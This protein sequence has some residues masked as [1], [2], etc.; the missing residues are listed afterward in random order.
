M[1]ANEILNDAIRVRSVLKA[2]IHKLRTCPP[3]QPIPE[4]LAV[5]VRQRLTSL[6]EFDGVR[7]LDQLAQ[8][9][10]ADSNQN[11]LPAATFNGHPKL[12]ARRKAATNP[13]DPRDKWVYKKC[14]KGIK[15]TSIVAELKKIASKRDW[16]IV[17]TKNRI[18]QIGNEYADDHSLPRPPGAKAC[19]W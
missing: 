16:K 12:P 14:C 2:I 9:I 7:L 5:P 8:A 17:S 1:V 18:Q 3:G 13:N 10:V 4:N 11:M 15:Y 6:G 19:S